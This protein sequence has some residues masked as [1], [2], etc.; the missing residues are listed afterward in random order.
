MNKKLYLNVIRRLRRNITASYAKRHFLDL[1][2][3]PNSEKRFNIEDIKEKVYKKI[4]RI[5]K[6]NEG[7]SEF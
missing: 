6:F 1:Y 3:L 2:Y 5:L 7:V 4:C